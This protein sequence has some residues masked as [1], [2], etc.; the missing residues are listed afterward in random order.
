MEKITKEVRFQLMGFLCTLK[1][2]GTSLEAKR[3]SIYQTNEKWLPSIDVA[4]SKLKQFKKLKLKCKNSRKFQ[5]LDQFQT[6]KNPAQQ[7]SKK[8][9]TTSTPT[10]P[11]TNNQSTTK[12]EKK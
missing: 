2:L 10:L 8:P 7:S 3:N 9:L 12:F 4:K 6:F 5:A 11:N 1:T